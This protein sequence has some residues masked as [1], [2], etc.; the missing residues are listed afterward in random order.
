MQVSQRFVTLKMQLQKKYLLICQKS[1]KLLSSSLSWQWQ[2]SL[3]C[4]A[5]QWYESLNPFWST[6]SKEIRIVGCW[7]LLHRYF[8]SLQVSDTKYYNKKVNMTPKRLLA[9]RNGNHVS[10]MA[11]F[12]HTIQVTFWMESPGEI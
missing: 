9:F 2:R 1:S 7:K 5:V 10:F 12:F 6:T 8:R 4:T 3:H 11:V